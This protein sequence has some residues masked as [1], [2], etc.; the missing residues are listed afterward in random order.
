[1][2]VR[3][4]IE[5]LNTIVEE[6]PEAMDFGIWVETDTEIERACHLTTGFCS[7]N[8]YILGEDA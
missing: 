8:I 5:K 6:N 2:L 4:L 3:E 1:M 7:R